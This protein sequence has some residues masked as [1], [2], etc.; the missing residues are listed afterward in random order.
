MRRALRPRRRSRLTRP[1]PWPPRALLRLGLILVA[2]AVLLQLGI[3]S[4]LVTAGGLVAVR[5]YNQVTAEGMARLRAA[6]ALDALPPTRILDRHGRLLAEISDTSRGLHATEPL[7][8]IPRA[9]QEAIVATED[10]S[11]W[12]NLGFSPTSV[13]RAALTDL[14]HRAPVQGASG[15]T[16]QLIKRLVL[17]N[18]DTVQRKLQEVL[19]A[20]AVSRPGSGFSKADILDLYLNSVFFGHEA[21]GVEAA[22]R[23]FFG[24]D[25]WQLDLAQCALLA[26]LVQAPT[27]YD[28]LGPAGPAPALRRLHTVLDGMRAV[29]VITPAQERAA[30]AE[31]AHFVFKAPG[32]RLTATRSVAPYWTDW[33]VNLLG[34]DSPDPALAAV[35]ARAG[36]L[37]AGL[38][39]TTTLDLPLY[40][41]AEQIM[42][43][44]V[45]QLAGFNVRDAA[46]VM[47]DPP[48]AECLAMVGGIN[49]GGTATGSQINMAA[50]PRS[51]GSS[52]K[53]YTYLTAF[54]QGWSP[55]T[56]LQ[57]EPMSWPDLGEPGGVYAPVDYDHA[58]HGAVTLRMALANSLNMPAV[59]TLAAVGIPNVIKT[60]EDLGV[61]NLGIRARG[62]GLSL[63][64]GS[65]PIP[66]WQMAQAYNVV[67]AGGVFRPMASI[68]GIADALGTPLYSYRPPAGRLVL[69]PQY[70]Y[71]MTSVLSDNAA[72]VP[73][74]GSI[75]PLR[76]GNPGDA[77]TAPAAVKTGTSQDFR[78]NLTIGFTPNLL[79]ATWVGNPDDS[80]MVNVEGVDGAGPIWHDLME[81]A[82]QHEHLPVRSFAVP[83]GIFLEHVSSS[84]YLADA[85]TAWPI[86]D[87]FAAGT[88]P[89]RFDPGGG[90]TYLEQRVWTQ[91]FSVDGGALDSAPAG[92]VPVTGPRLQPN[93]TPPSG[94]ASP[95]TSGLLSQR[96]SDPNL[97]GGRYYTYSAVYVNG[98]L[99]WRYTCQ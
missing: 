2:G 75:T 98:Q 39:I 60:A 97:C 64:L 65:V 7:S 83:P 51:P 44:Q 67:A 84:G 45:H 24:R 78:D 61:T 30:Q 52:F 23:V 31:A 90:K 87:Y 43:A 93:P 18:S 42:N 16:Q 62:A 34:A 79:T 48:T 41:R 86:T 66:L 6:Q 92:L 46:V 88:V 49:Y 59:R 11:F 50:Q 35:V 19:I 58:W 96:P 57:D 69:A 85:Q 95:G 10:R 91:D 99:M 68:L 54:K 77:I 40:N 81:W 71:L 63:T 14:T 28:P 89:H 22:A 21:Y 29:G 33:I 15:I 26:G 5:Y 82:L 38:T 20:T 72:R 1:R 80:P 3:L 55:A 74:F 76:L 12:S 32:W 36:G 8:R 70:A 47:L 4:L 25:I 56:M 73:E 17:T 37:T 27:A 53:L 94:A 9:M 13:V